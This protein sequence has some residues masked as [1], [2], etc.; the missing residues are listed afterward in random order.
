LLRFLLNNNAQLLT[1]WKVRKEM[2]EKNERER[3]QQQ[4]KH[5][6]Q[7][8]LDLT[9]FPFRGFDGI[10][11]LNFPSLSERKKIHFRRFPPNQ[12]SLLFIL[13]YFIIILFLFYFII[14]FSFLSLFPLTLIFPSL[15]SIFYY[16]FVKKIFI[17][18]LLLFYLLI[19]N[20]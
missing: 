3:K 4:N 8:Q 18:V 2:K 13:F 14:L 9:N 17:V 12:F 15:S 16:F 7:H 1:L 5:N 11:I 6:K 20:K 10:K 19:D